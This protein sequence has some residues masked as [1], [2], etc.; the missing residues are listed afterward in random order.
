MQIVNLSHKDDGSSNSIKIENYTTYEYNL[1]PQTIETLTK[2]Q[3]LYIK[4]ALK[5]I[6][7]ENL[8]NAKLICDYITSNEID[9]NIKE[10][11]KK[12]KIKVLICL[13]NFHSGRFFRDI[14][15]VNILSYQI[16]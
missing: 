6:A 1:V 8:E 11:I 5:K 3:H 15:K 7:L 14:T 13:S 16:A 2:L 4:M 10:S 12:E 9:F